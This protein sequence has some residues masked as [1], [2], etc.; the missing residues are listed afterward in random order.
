MNE[1]NRNRLGIRI[2]RISEKRT[3]QP[4]YCKK[5]GIKYTTFRY[6]WERWNRTSKSEFV[7][8]AGIQP[9]IDF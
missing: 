6:H 5:R 9:Y 7:E 8:I 2:S 1:Q 3:S 4:A